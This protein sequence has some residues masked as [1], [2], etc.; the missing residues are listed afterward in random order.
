[1]SWTGPQSLC[2]PYKAKRISIYPAQLSWAS[3]PR[4]Q[5]SS[6]RNVLRVGEPYKLNPSPSPL[7]I[8]S[9]SR[10]RIATLNPKP[11]TGCL[12]PRGLRSP[13]AKSRPEVSFRLRA[14]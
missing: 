5:A 3:R 10:A 4:C 7:V 8:R 2:M 13:F 1:M 12:V 11:W 14:R 9:I 6:I